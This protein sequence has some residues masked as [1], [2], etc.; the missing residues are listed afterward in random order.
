VRADPRRLALAVWS[1]Q[2]GG[3]ETMMLALAKRMRELGA[4]AEVVILG[5]EGPLVDRLS[6]QGLPYRLVGLSRGR[7]ILRR[8]RHCARV[9][10]AAG[11]DGALLPECG[12]LGAALRVG[13]YNHPIVAVEHGIVLFPASGI[14][15][16]ILD[17]ANRA[18]GAWADDAE[19]AV[20]EHVL[21][22][23][24]GGPHARRL[25]R[26]YNGV[27]PDQFAPRHD[28]A[29]RVADP[30]L[31]AGFAGR[32]IRGKGLDILVH[33]LAAARNLVSVR[34]LVAGDGPDR[35]ELASLVSRVGIAQ[36]VEF[37]GMVRDMD[38]FWQSCDIA[39]VPSDTWIESFCMSALE[40]M[41]CGK[42]VI[43]TCNGALPELVS[44]GE[45]GMLVPP[46]DVTALARAIVSYTKRP[47]MR[48][49]HAAAARSRAVER[50]SVDQCARAYLALFNIASRNS[51]RH[52]GSD[53]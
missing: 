26:I 25:K 35:D 9:M 46:G 22:R 38:R 34:L 33:A 5:G 28:V 11:P 49:K 13:G 27:D 19:V 14:A 17:M 45:S 12:F 7:D 41:S 44:H 18:S 37:F 6:D 52:R 3:A 51:K 20:S 16:R 23:M 15:R 1:A 21:S 40:A 4:V 42:P 24:R 43:A 29:G 2:I 32:L 50:F 10:T 39:I 8:P 47:S 30:S 36:D 48:H 53:V 31:V